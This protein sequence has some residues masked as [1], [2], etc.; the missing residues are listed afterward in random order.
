MALHLGV[1]AILR[2]FKLEPGMLAG[3]VYA[4]LHVNDVGL[5]GVLAEPGEWTV[6]KLAEALRAPL[7]TTSS[8]LDRLEERGV[9]VRQRSQTDRRLMHVQVTAVGHRLASRL[10]AKQIETC[11]D[12]LLLLSER[13][14]EELIRLVAKV[15]R[16]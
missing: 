16:G 7:S 3:S 5:L 8:A 6:R 13:E 4:E 9:I 2:R 11:R 10:Q 12:M 14:R 15:A 1:A